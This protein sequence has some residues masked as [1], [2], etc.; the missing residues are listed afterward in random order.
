MQQIISDSRSEVDSSSSD[1]WVMVAAL[2]VCETKIASVA[3]GFG[4]HKL[5]LLILERVF[6][7]KLL[8]HSIFTYLL[9]SQPDTFMIST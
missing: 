7:I 5:D 6:T 2:K 4:V 3:A 1:F 8:S 9:V